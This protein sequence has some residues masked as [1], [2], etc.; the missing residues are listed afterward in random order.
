M[1]LFRDNR[2]SG[3]LYR[4]FST[5]NGRTW[6]N[7][8][9]SDFPDARSK[10]H[11]LR[12][13]NGKYVLVSNSHFEHRQW[14]TLALSDNGMVFDKLFFLVEGDRDG[15]DYPHMI[16]HEGYLYIAHSGGHGGRKQSVE[17]QRVNISDLEA[18]EMPETSN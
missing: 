1:T 18:L 7:P 9:R 15:V 10:F 12:M 8:V 5:D 14:L 6:S 3:Y 13:S 17:V 4:S 2:R 16:E 11:G